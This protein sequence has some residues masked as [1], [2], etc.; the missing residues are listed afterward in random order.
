ME[1]VTVRTEPAKTGLA[2]PRE[3]VLHRIPWKICH[4]GPAPV[5]KYFVTEEIQGAPDVH[6]GSFQGRG[7]RGQEVKL[8]EGYSGV[9]VE[10]HVDG[11][12]QTFVPVKRFDR[13]TYWNHDVMPSSC[14][15]MSQ[16][17]EWMDMADTIHSN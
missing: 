9:V 3:C 14:D 7:L 12:E 13:L 15:T 2:A 6:M 16:C 1:G 17:M 11:D 10:K 4:D 8:P 5:S